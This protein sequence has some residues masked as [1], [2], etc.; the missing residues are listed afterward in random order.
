MAS[1]PKGRDIPSRPEDARRSAL[2]QTRGSGSC[3]RSRAPGFDPQER[4]V[5]RGRGSDPAVGVR[6]SKASA[7]IR[8]RAAREAPPERLGR[9]RIA[10][11]RPAA[12]VREGTQTAGFRWGFRPL[13][14][15][16]SSERLTHVPTLP[17]RDCVGEWDPVSTNGQ[18]PNWPWVT[19]PGDGYDGRIGASG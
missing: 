12:S 17:P 1:A 13:L 11:E 16:R 14:R 9:C 4:S 10:T 8:R 15:D 6:P 7:S 19:L 3:T 5:G 2:R 18:R